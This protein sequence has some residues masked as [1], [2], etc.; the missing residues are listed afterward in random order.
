MLSAVFLLFVSLFTIS[1]AAQ[2]SCFRLRHA[3]RAFQ[4]PTAQVWN[5]VTSTFVEKAPVELCLFAVLLVYLDP[6]N[7]VA[8]HRMQSTVRFF[9]LESVVVSVYG[10]SYVMC[11]LFSLDRLIGAVQGLAHLYVTVLQTV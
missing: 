9:S 10:W 11:H 3:L 1:A 6:V 4:S 2:V 8:A 5:I 7:P